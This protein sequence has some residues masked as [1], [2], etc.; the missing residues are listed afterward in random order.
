IQVISIVILLCTTASLKLQFK[1]PGFYA[2]LGAI[3]LCSTPV[4]VWNSQNDWITFVHL[5]ERTGLVDFNQ[6][7]T[8]KSAEAASS[9]GFEWNPLDIFNYLGQHLGVYSPLFFAGLAWTTVLAWKRFRR[10]QEETFIGAFGLPIVVFYFGLSVLKMGELNWTAPGFVCLGLL[11]PKYWEEANLS[12]ALKQRLSIAAF[13]LSGVLTVLAV[14]PEVIRSTGLTWPYSFDT[15]KRWSGWATSSEHIAAQVARFEAEID[16]KPFLIANRY[17][18]CAAIAF[19]FPDESGVMRPTP[20][21]PLV[22]TIEPDDK[23]ARKNQFAF[24]PAYQRDLQFLGKS[25]LFLTD[26]LKSESPPRNV[27][28]A[29]RDWEV[30]SLVDINRRGELLRSWKVFACYDY[31]GLPEE[32]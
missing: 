14:N 3:L 29:F 15:K 32:R 19:Y 21:Y 12:A 23:T 18:T 22:H 9:S 4:L 6:P 8:A 20:R 11:L 16:D 10:S 5:I 31:Q 13:A 28:E 1:R 2:M 26:S 17:Q 30:Y 24:W 27:R 7:E 25:A